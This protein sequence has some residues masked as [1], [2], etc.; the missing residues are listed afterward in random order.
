MQELIIAPQVIQYRLERWKLPDGR[1]VVAQLP[2]RIKNNHFGPMLRAY[3]LH[4]YHHQCVTQPLLHA[5][6]LEWGIDISSGQLN[7]ILTSGQ[8]KF[9][10]EKAALLT[11]GLSVSDYIQVDDTGARHQ[12][13]NGYCTFIGN[14]FFS[15]FSSTKSKSRINFLEL[16]RGEESDYQL[17]SESFKYM[18]RNSVAPWV[19]KKLK[20]ASGRIFASKAAW[21]QHLIR[22]NISNKNHVR[23]VTEAALIGSLLHYRFSRNTAI[24]SDDA[25]QFNVFLHALCW[26]HAER[27]IKSLIPMNDIQQ[28]ATNWARNEIW[29]IYDAL[30]SYKVTPN[31]EMKIKII[32]RFNKFC[33][34][35]TDYQLLNVCL[36]RFRSN[37]DELLLVLERPEI[38]LHNNQSES[39][40]REY[41]KRRKISGSTRSDEGR[42]CRDTF[43]SL[44]KTAV[45]LGIGFWSYLID[46]MNNTGNILPLSELVLNAAKI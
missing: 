2:E 20:M 10:E 29:E 19:R 11:A 27:G 3:I 9:H 17:I 14:A 42:K 30:L 41:V 6:L 24:L 31:T 28:K 15:W 7:N 38:P 33:N 25:G 22:L 35:K 26:I 43:A 5:Q 23:I 32:K 18:E 45:K 16:L 12:G 8:E 40:I 44:K 34:T 37:K 46:R 39:D 36:N 21:E 13:K 4:Q 1:C